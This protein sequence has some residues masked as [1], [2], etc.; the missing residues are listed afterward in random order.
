MSLVAFHGAVHANEAPD[1]DTL[2]ARR[3]IE[4]NTNGSVE[5][6]EEAL[7]KE[8]IIKVGLDDMTLTSGMCEEIIERTPD[9]TL[10]ERAVAAANLTQEVDII[11]DS[12]V[13]AAGKDINGDGRV[14]DKD[15]TAAS[16]S[17]Y[18]AAH[19]AQQRVR[20]A[21]EKAGTAAGAIK[22]VS[23]EPVAA[24]Q[25]YPS[26][27]PAPT[28]QPAPAPR[29]QPAP[30]PPLNE[31]PSY[32]GVQS[33]AEVAARREGASPE[34]AAAGSDCA[35]NVALLDG[36]MQE[37]V[38]GNLSF[39]APAKEMQWKDKDTIGLVVAP[40][41]TATIEQLQQY[42]DEVEGG[43]D[44][45]ARCVGL[46]PE[47]E[48]DFIG[49]QFGITLLTGESKRDILGATPTEWEW[50]LAAKEQGRNILHLNVKAYLSSA[51]GGKPRSIVQ[52]PFSD[53]INVSATPWQGLTDFVSR[54]L[55]LLMTGFFT[56]LTT[57]LVPLVV[58]WWRRRG[59]SET[60][61][62][63]NRT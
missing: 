24:L 23:A 12:M 13:D 51:E 6:L 36:T 44:V 45:K 46:A 56:I 63:T 30:Q 16:S 52:S 19:A 40:A 37:L 1:G 42:L 5:P 43:S 47:M 14:D 38:Q 31:L 59:G 25:Q 60:S 22:E 4:S 34:A 15:T 58:F 2:T 33:K 35:A 39:E 10:V 54:N 28:P 32:E 61:E 21:V 55:Q 3:C 17:S 48:A 29:P 26:A 57:I 9:G 49:P 62:P 20:T 41:A 7:M 11:E 50:E 8:G 53:Y 18:A 27:P